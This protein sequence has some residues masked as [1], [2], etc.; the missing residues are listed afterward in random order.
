MESDLNLLG[1]DIAVE[2]IAD[3]AT[4]VDGS[5]EWRRQLAGQVRVKRFKC[6]AVEQHIDIGLQ[7]G[8]GEITADSQLG[9]AP[10]QQ[11]Q[12]G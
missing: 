5:F 10:G 2:R 11:F 1:Q 4:E 12:L 7:R 3:M 8:D 6:Y 9:L